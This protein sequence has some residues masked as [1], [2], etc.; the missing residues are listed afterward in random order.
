MEKLIKVFWYSVLSI[1]PNACDDGSDQWKELSEMLNIRSI[2][3]GPTAIK[4]SRGEASSLYEDQFEELHYGK[5]QILKEGS[6]DHAVVNIFKRQIRRKRSLKKKIWD[7]FINPRYIKT[8]W[9]GELI[10]KLSQTYDKIMIAEEGVLNRDLE[11][12]WMNF[13]VSMITKVSQMPWKIDDQFVGTWFCK[14]VK[15]NVEDWWRKYCRLHWMDE[16][17]EK[18]RKNV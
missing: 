4:Y 12:W 5:G 6:C 9:S 18:W 1:I 11:W 14:W 3:K 2:I 8:I 15:K 13:W 10:M 17:I 16:G 7:W